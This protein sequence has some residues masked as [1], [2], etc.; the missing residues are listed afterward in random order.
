MKKIIM[1]LVLVLGIL[2]GCQEKESKE[3]SDYGQE[4]EKAQEIT[5]IS[6]NTANVAAVLD[7]KKELE[8][9]VEELKIEKWELAKAPEK[10]EE[11][12]SFCFSQE[13][14]VE[15]GET[16]T[17]GKLYDICK[18]TVYDVPYISLEMGSIHMTF[19]IPEDTAEELN[20]YF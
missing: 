10:A 15:L 1:A 16:E 3:I 6:A 2:C 14:T 13:K 19:E 18:L 20:G 4:L 8:K 12:G 9:F 7:E 17:D 5:V 11:T